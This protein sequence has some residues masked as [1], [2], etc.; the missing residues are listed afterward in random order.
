MRQSHAFIKTLRQPPAGETSANAKLLEQAGFVHKLMAGVY[1][2]LP[3]GWRV[4]NKI[5]TIIREELTAIDAVEVYLP[6]LQPKEL[7][8]ATG[9][10]QELAPIMYQFTD[11]TDHPIGLGTT[12]EETIT[13]IVGA[14][15]NSYKDLPLALFQIQDKFRDEPRARSGLIRARE[16][17]MKDLYSFHTDEKDLDVYYEKVKKAY[18][19]IFSRCGLDAVVVEAS[20]GSFTKKYSHEFQ[21]LTEVGED[22]ILFDPKT[23]TGKNKE[24]AS[25]ADGFEERRGIEVGNI[26]KLGTRFSEPLKAQ[27]TD[28]KGV[29]QPMIMASYGIGPGRVMAT[30]VEL[31]HDT[32]GII[33][34]EAVAPADVH[35]IRLGANPAIAQAAEALY[36]D[37]LKQGIDV[38]FDDRDETAGTKLNDADLI[39][40]PHRVIMSDKTGTKTIEYKRRGS[41][42][43]QKI[44]PKDLLKKVRS[45]V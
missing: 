38:L 45:D 36:A 43:A 42:E 11:H 44:K 17:A 29:Q 34:P 22:K 23:N 26:F 33:W 24:I 1:A 20:G 39:G 9:R 35:L 18:Q 13:R 8:D 15:V 14:R 3:L 31:H 25:G 30:I 40:I 28:N 27:F 37:L 4:F 21:V 5:T 19:N 32:H 10:W 12:H 16:F 41:S 2:Y 7:W 6:A